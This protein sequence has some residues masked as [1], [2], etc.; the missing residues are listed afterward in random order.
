MD[1][2]NEVGDDLYGAEEAIAAIK[3]LDEL[4]DSIKSG[5]VI[6]FLL[7]DARDAAEKAKQ[8]LLTINPENP[9]AIREL[10]WMVAR[11]EALLSWV[12]R[13]RDEGQS[14]KIMIAESDRVY[15]D[16]LMRGE[17]TEEY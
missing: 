5:G 10:Q 1:Y 2:D 3:R 13:V 16:G 12:E 8:A 6:A 14:A 11:N 15:L 9:A 7:L 4:E 17:E